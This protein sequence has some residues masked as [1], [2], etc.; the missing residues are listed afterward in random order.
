MRII[1]SRAWHPDL[2]GGEMIYNGFHIAPDGGVWLYSHEG[3]TNAHDL[4][5]MLYT[6]LEDNSEPS[7]EICEGDIIEFG[8][9]MGRKN[10][11]VMYDDDAASWVI[12]PV[13]WWLGMAFKLN[14]G[15]KIIGNIYENPEL[16]EKPEA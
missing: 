10:D 7:K 2:N 1:K 11:A 9:Y 13:K 15:A 8:K 14:T 5:V 12:G 4:I 16:L 3:L 6:G